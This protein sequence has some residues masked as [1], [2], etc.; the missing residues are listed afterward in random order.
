MQHLLDEMNDDHFEG[1]QRVLDELGYQQ[2]FFE[3][4]SPKTGLH[5][6]C[7]WDTFDFERRTFWTNIMIYKQQADKL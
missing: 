1:I 3:N 6:D 5:V 4:G 2:P 7:T